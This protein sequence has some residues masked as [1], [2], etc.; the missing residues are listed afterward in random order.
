LEQYQSEFFAEYEL[1]DEDADVASYNMH[2]QLL[3]DSFLEQVNEILEKSKTEGNA[4]QVEELKNE[5]D[6]LRNKQSRLT[7]RLVFKKIGE[8]S[9]KVRKHSIPVFKKFIEIA[10]KELVSWGIKQLLGGPA[11]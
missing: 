3:I 10:S 8:I 11:S 2:Q 6:D 5:I 7:K 4:A 9:S 1:L